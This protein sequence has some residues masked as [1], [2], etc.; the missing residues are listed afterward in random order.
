MPGFLCV[1]LSANGR[2]TIDFLEIYVIITFMKMFERNTGVPTHQRIVD[3]IAATAMGAVFVFGTVMVDRA[4]AQIVPMPEAAAAFVDETNCNVQ[5]SMRD[6]LGAIGF[7]IGGISRCELADL[8][9]NSTG[10]ELTGSV[11]DG[12][13]VDDSQYARN[14]YVRP[15]LTAGN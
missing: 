4:G 11:Q 8:L 3:G 5:E 13:L 2:P 1:C 15:P 10:A 14:E 12:A 6:G 9:N 7:D